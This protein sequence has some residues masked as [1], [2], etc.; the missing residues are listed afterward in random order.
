MVSVSADSV[1]VIRRTP[2]VT[3]PNSTALASAKAEPIWIVS[4][5][6]LVTS[7]TPAKPTMSAPQ[8]TGPTTSFRI[9]IAASVANSGAEKL[10]ATALASGIRLKAMTRNVCAKD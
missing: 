10:I 1:D 4:A 2:T 8:R 9:M 5:P 6:G 7:N 3:V